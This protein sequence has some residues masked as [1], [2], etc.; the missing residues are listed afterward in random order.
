MSTYENVIV[1]ID[2]YHAT[3]EVSRPKALNA[4][5]IETLIEIEKVILNL[6]EDPSIK[7]IILT[8]HGEK[9]FVAGADIAAMRDMTAEQADQFC[10]QGHRTM[11]TIEESP[12]PVIAAV[13]GFA[14]G[15]GCELALAC[16]FIYESENAKF[17]LPETKLG[18][19]PGFG[20]T[21]R[22]PRVVGAARAKEL[23]FTGRVINATEACA[24]GMVN[25]V[26][27][28]EH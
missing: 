11:D 7:A 12:K 26:V 15:G 4:L 24:W 3:I 5:N 14:L 17:G 28:Q 21:Q 1:K 18:L 23:I 22:M 19:F 2:E 16:D 8:G 9:A 13:N 27:P 25:K 6:N 10:H 20:G